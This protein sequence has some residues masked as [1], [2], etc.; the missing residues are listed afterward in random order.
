MVKVCAC[1]YKVRRGD[2]LQ[3]GVAVLTQDGKDADY[4]LNTDVGLPVKLVTNYKLFPI[5]GCMALR[6]GAVVPF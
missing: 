5:E 6:S 3:W 4:I 1:Q 2:P